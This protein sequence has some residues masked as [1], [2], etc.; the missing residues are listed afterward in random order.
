MSKSTRAHTSA[1]SCIR[2]LL[3][4][5]KKKGS[6]RARRMY[7]EMLP[8]IEAEPELH[9]NL[10][11]VIYCHISRNPATPRQMQIFARARSLCREWLCKPVFAQTIPLHVWCRLVDAVSADGECALND[12]IWQTNPLLTRF[13][14]PLRFSLATKTLH[15]SYSSFDSYVYF[16][17][18]PLSSEAFL[19]G[20]YDGG[21]V[22]AAMLHTD[23][24]A[25]ASF[26]RG[27]HFY[28]RKMAKLLTEL[29]RSLPWFLSCNCRDIVYYLFH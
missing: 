1:A 18:S 14:I 16:A 21:R 7:Q 20:L 9:L 13:P 6:K 22:Q 4:A 27:Q 23:R 11:E 3:L 26:Q 29:K 5:S 25:I 24:E 12:L 19:L 2:Q 28:N 17:N 10:W 15:H 8:R